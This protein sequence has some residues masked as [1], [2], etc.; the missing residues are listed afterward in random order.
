MYPTGLWRSGEIVPDNYRLTMPPGAPP[1]EVTLDVAL[2]DRRTFEAVGETHIEGLHYDYLTPRA[3][4]PPPEILIDHALGIDDIRLPLSVEGTTPLKAEIDWAVLSQPSHD[5]RLRW[6]FVAPYGTA[7]EQQTPLAE[8][9]DPAGWQ[10]GACGA[11]VLGRYKLPLP[12]DAPSGEYTVMLVV[13]DE[14]GNNIGAPVEAGHLTY[15]AIDRVFEMPSVERQFAV[16]FGGVLAL[17]GYG[18]RHETESLYLD[19]IWHALVDPP[20]DYKSFVHLYDPA[21]GEIVTQVDSMPRN[22]TY[23]TSQW[24]A[25]EFIAETLTLDLSQ[26]RPGAY[27]LG[28]GWYDPTTGD[29]LPASGP[30]GEIWPDDRVVL[31]EEIVVP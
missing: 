15:R 14:S 22:Y 17:E 30:T 26:V 9:S 19:V 3:C 10:P 2:Y 16:D 8:G 31:D 7:W 4:E 29:R 13:Q 12:S 24:V 23:P 20:A 18:L 25:G 11:S 5:Y 21:T 1:G 27:R 28:I 6:Q